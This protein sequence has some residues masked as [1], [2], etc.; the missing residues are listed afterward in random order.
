MSSTAADI[1]NGKI[2]SAYLFYGE[3]AYKRRH[4]KEMLKEAVTKGNTMNLSEYEGKSIDWQAVYDTSQTM[5]FFAERR[6][7]IVENSGKFS[8]KKAE[9]EDT[10]GSER[11]DGAGGKNIDAAGTAGAGTADAGGTAADGAGAGSADILERIL[12][13]LPET[14]CIAFFEE[15]AAKNKKIYKLIASNGVVCECGADNEDTVINW[16]ARGFAGAGKKVRRST[17]EL[18]TGR[19]GLDYD[20]LHTEFEKIISYAGDKE[21]ISDSDVMAISSE[22][23]ESRIFDMLT[24]MSEKNVRKVLAKYRDLLANKEAPLYILA[25]LRIQFR[26]M[27]QAAEL[28]S[29]GLRSHEIAKQ[30][31]K[32]VFA[33]DKILRCLRHFTKEQIEEILDEISETDRKSKSGEIQDQIGVELL[34]V[35]FSS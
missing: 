11:I 4:Y 35:K 12:R 20:L 2:A 8:G 17:L 9:K 21:I 5:P 33:V 25:M 24:A 30:I 1:K 16:L 26:T 19:V 29:R 23:T 3:E 15:S 22:V 10:G 6:L 28:S 31:G 7:I 13:E 18:L 14:T 34:L 32:P 27:L